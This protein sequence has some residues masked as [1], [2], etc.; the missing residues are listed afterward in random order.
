MAERVAE[1]AAILSRELPPLC[2]IAIV[3]DS[4]KT[5]ASVMIETFIVSTS[6][7]S[8]NDS[9]HTDGLGSARQ[10]TNPEGSDP[11]PGRL[12]SCN[13]RFIQAI[14]RQA[15]L[16]NTVAPPGVASSG[17]NPCRMG[18]SY[19]TIQLMLNLL[20]GRSSFVEGDN[21]RPWMPRP[22]ASIPRAYNKC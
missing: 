20:P 15:S 12:L 3:L 4:A 21:D 13:H 19:R 16:R 1:L 10:A 8:L 14:P 18:V 7:C 9:N 11:R 17:H 22:D 5:T 2:A 6:L